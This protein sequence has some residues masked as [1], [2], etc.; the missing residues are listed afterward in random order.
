LQLHCLNQ[1]DN[2]SYQNGDEAETIQELAA[3]AFTKVC[4]KEGSG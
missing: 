1:V 3:D 2:N 4:L